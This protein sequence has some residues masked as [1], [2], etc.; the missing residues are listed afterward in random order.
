MTGVKVWWCL[1]AFCFVIIFDQ[2]TTTHI[3]CIPLKDCPMAMNLINTQ[4]YAPKTIKF[5]KNS[6]CGIINHEPLIFCPSFIGCKTR[7][8]QNGT[9]AHVHNCTPLLKIVNSLNLNDY[10]RMEF[11]EK[12]RCF[13]PY[14]E[15]FRVCC[16]M[17]DPFHS[18]DNSIWDRASHSPFKP[19]R[20]TRDDS[21]DRSVDD[22]KEDFD[23]N[24]ECGISVNG[25]E[26]ITG[27]KSTELGEYPW[28]AVLLYEGQNGLIN[29]CGG[30]L[31]TDRY[32]L[33]AAHCLHKDILRRYNLKELKYVVLGEYDLRNRTDCIYGECS[34]P[35]LYF[36]IKNKI[37]HSK[38]S[39]ITYT[40]DIALIELDKKV[41]YSDYVKPICLPNKN[42][43]L[44]GNESFVIAGWGQTSTRFS[45]PT[46]QK[47]RVKLSKSED[48]KNISKRQICAGSGDGKDTCNGDSGGPLMLGKIQGSNIVNFLI[49]ITS[50]GFNNCG[51]RPSFFSF[52][53]EYLD[54][55]KQNIN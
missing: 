23:A 31:I 18:D 38:F 48:C 53:P 9:C 13:S 2:S 45:S 35:P 28:M 10:E 16:P 29:G 55:I 8:A 33:T 32:V 22:S 34:E 4:K 46:K 19:H 5:L 27:G 51:T 37:V 15:D 43:D 39:N 50:Y 14:D 25:N 36:S 42:I 7:H 1:F 41:K 40:N 6:H 54:W 47:A 17:K 30:S 12:H 26:R 11:Y 3:E 20:P 49:G 21:T 52:V 44:Q 24:E